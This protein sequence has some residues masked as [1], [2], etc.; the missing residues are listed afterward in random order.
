MTA[1]RS[2]NAVLLLKTEDIEGTGETPT[3]GSNAI[4]VQ[5]MQVNPRPNVIQTNEHTGSL[6]GLG[7]IVGGTPVDVSFEVYV[8][9]SGVAGTAPEVGP[10]LKACGWGETITSTAVPASAE[11]CGAGGSTAFTILGSSAGATADLYNGMPITFNASSTTFITDYSAAK[12]A[13]F[14]TTLTTAAVSTIEYQIPVNV[15]YAPA[16]TSI[17]SCTIWAYR[18]GVLDKI[19]GCRGTFTTRIDAGG[20]ALFSFNFMGLVSTQSDA[21]VVAPTLDSARPPVWRGGLCRYARTA[22]A[23]GQ[24]SLDNGATVI[25]PPDPEQAQGVSAAI[26]TDRRITGSMDP[27]SVLVATR[28]TFGN[29]TGGTK[30]TFL[31]R[32]GSTAGNR[33]AFTIPNMLLTGLSDSNRQGVRTDNVTFDAVGQ[34]GG[35]YIC[36]D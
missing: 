14:A 20:V 26:H 30:A 12:R 5:N 2:R 4:A 1:Y 13:D 6:D 18:D 31:A 32:V 8:K 33:F 15:L 19:V 17:A 21:S 16:S 27:N 3:A 22:M 29:L 28:D 34:D 10:A 7:S 9:G 25:R 11:V 35:A 24:L 36:F 23:L